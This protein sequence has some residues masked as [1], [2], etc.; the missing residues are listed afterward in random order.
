LARGGLYGRRNERVIARDYVVRAPNRFLLGF[1]R[2]WISD[3]NL[4]QFN[5]QSKTKNNDNSMLSGILLTCRQT[6]L[7]LSAA[8]WQ[9]RT[10]LNPVFA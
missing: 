2:Y 5:E 3:I 6:G 10:P 1:C 9:L 8:Y 4:A 7:S